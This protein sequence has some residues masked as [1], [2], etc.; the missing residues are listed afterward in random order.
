MTD[1]PPTDI[2][3]QGP[4]YSAIAMVERAVRNARPHRMTEAPRWVGVKDIFSYGSTT[5]KE[6]CRR[7]GLDPYEKVAGVQCDCDYD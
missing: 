4:E 3:D 1:K 2:F 6:L 5:S 7:F